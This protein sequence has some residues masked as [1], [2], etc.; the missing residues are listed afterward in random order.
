MHGLVERLLEPAELVTE[1]TRRDMAEAAGEIERLRER[2]SWKGIESAPRDG[3]DII[4]WDGVHQRIWS[5]SVWRE[6]AGPEMAGY[7]HWMA[8]PGGPESELGEKDE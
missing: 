3:R 4:V 7:T 2:C 5:T 1:E 6:H 8:L